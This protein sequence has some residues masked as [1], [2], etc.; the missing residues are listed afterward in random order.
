MYICVYVD[1]LPHVVMLCTLWYYIL[2][3]SMPCFL[4]FRKRHTFKCVFS[5]F[6]YRG[7]EIWILLIY[8]DLQYDWEY[9]CIEEDWEYASTDAHSRLVSSCG[10]RDKNKRRGH[11]RP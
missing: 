8:W 10:F 1:I 5:N 11:T 2:G 9:V 3:S 6:F 7:A 4:V